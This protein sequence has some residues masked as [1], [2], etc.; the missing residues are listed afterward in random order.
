MKIL[1]AN[2]AYGFAGMDRLFPS[3]R[4]QLNI[5][6]WGILT[7]EFLPL[8]RGKFASVSEERRVAY[9]KK[10]QHLTPLLEMIRRTAPDALVLNEVIYELYQ[11]SLEQDLRG[12]GFSAIAWGVSTHYS[13]TS[14][15]TLVATRE[16]GEA[17]PCTMPQRPSMGGG[18]GMA[19]IRLSNKSLSVFGMHLTYRNPP[20]FKK[21]LAYIADMAKYEQSQDS[22]VILAGDF[23]ES[24]AAICTHQDFNSLGL[25]SADSQE[26]LSCPTFLPKFLQKSLDHIFVP[27]DWQKRRAETIAF[28]SDHLALLVET[29]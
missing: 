10:N 14:I 12:M 22:Q 9:V 1:T 11:K 27:T 13:G 5:H 25:K 21:Q 8:L 29:G 19:G 24:E 3:L 16:P 2:I 23:N 7:Y 6:G 28:G 4:H 26:K 15:S 20:M 17:I 18:A